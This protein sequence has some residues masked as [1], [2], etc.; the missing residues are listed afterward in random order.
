MPV[1]APPSSSVAS[2]DSAPVLLMVSIES[3]PCVARIPNFTPWVTNRRVP[4]GLTATPNGDLTAVANVAAPT[5]ALDLASIAYT[6]LGDLVAPAT[7]TR[8]PFGSMGTPCVEAPMEHALSPVVAVAR[9]EA[10]A[11][12]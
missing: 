5:T 3:A 6:E 11:T 7:Y 1:V 12:T 8:V 10:W 2:K 9:T 4:S